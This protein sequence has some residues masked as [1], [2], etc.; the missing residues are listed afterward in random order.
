MS[1]RA[2][3]INLGFRAFAATRLHRV[4]A[5]FARG[6]GAILMFH[7]VRD[8]DLPDFAPNAGL[9]IGPQ[10]LDAL[11]T[12]LRESR[13]AIVTLDEA[14]ERVAL[15]APSKHPFVALTFDDGYRDTA[16][17][18]LP[19]LARHQAPAS[20]FITT[21]FAERDAR[22]WWLEL[23]HSVAALARININIGNEV[24]D[25]ATSNAA[26]KSAAY[27]TLYA[28]LRAG[29]EECLLEVCAALAAQAGI[30][31]RALVED[32]CLDWDGVRALG[33]H[34]LITLGAHT[35]TH[36]MLAKHSSEFSRAEMGSSRTIIAAR[37]GCIV[38]HLAYPVGDPTSAGPREFEMARD[39]GFISAL[40]TRPGMLFPEHRA[41]LTA[42]PRLSVNGAHQSVEA[43]DVLLSGAAFMLWNRGRRINVA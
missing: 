5:P 27:A 31:T 1:L 2:D 28:K 6:M 30:D 35:L 42:L 17:I 13:I 16:D 19:I 23:E 25:L 38:R 36:P 34:P 12:Y 3:A 32:A 11:L 15:G 20:V 43:L 7:R 21:G 14:V 18:A 24:F 10:F 26:E 41:H 9:E 8:G 22:M 29:P 40:T 33:S 37:C 39:L 4:L